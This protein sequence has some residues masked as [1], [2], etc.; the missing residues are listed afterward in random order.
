MA[1]L[2]FWGAMKR[3]FLAA[4]LAVASGLL[5]APQVTQ[6]E[7]TAAGMSANASAAEA[8]DWRD[9]WDDREWRFRERWQRSERRATERWQR[10]LAQRNRDWSERIR[11]RMERSESRRIERMNRAHER[12]MERLDRLNRRN[13]ER[14]NR[15]NR[16]WHWHRWGH[17]EMM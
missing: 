8:Q 7:P 3:I 16:H 5:S 12:R 9:R 13:F 17:R 15:M 6:A 1:R 11:D 14:M 4:S 2:I 10:R